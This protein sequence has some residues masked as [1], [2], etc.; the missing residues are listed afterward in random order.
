MSGIDLFRRGLSPLRQ[1]PWFTLMG[2]TSI[3][4]ALTLIALFA[5]ISLNMQQ[6]VGDWSRDFQIVI[7]LDPPPD[8]TVARQWQ[9]ALGSMAETEEVTY[10]SSADALQRFSTRL[11][12]DAALLSGIGSDVL[13]ASFTLK[14]RPEFRQRDAVKLLVARIAQ[15]NEWRDV[16]YGAGWIERFDAVRRLLHVSGITLGLFLFFSAF[17]IVATT[18]RL[19]LL[20]RKTEIE[21]LRLLGASPLYIGLPFLLEGGVLGIMGGTVALI[22]VYL[23]YQVGL[24][25][26]L[27]SLL[28]LLGVER[29]VFLPPLWQFALIIGGAALGFFASF[30]AMRRLSK[31]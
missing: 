30:V 16:H 29:V 21:I 28:Q 27:L 15:K 3:A 26:G 18:I 24:Q 9:I 14:L 20:T 10:V 8:E 11:G 5:L 17:L 13:P 6:A 7:Y 4:V 23:F 31:V 19:I 25:Q 2:V 12:N 1:H 22:F